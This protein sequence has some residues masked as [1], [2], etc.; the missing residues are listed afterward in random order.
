MTRETS[1]G[2]F[3]AA[4]PNDAPSRAQADDA[5]AAFNAAFSLEAGGVG[6]YRR[7]AA[8]RR[9]ASFWQTAELI[10]L[11]ADSYQTSADPDHRRHIRALARGVQLR[12]GRHWT[13]V[14][15][16]NDDVMWMVLAALRAYDT[17]SDVHC[18][19]AATANFDRAW[20]RAWSP[21]LGGG[22]WW[23]TARREKNACVNGPAAIAACRLAVALDDP[24]YLERARH[25]YAWVRDHLYEEESGRVN[26]HVR[27]AA[28]GIV[29]DR[30]LF[31][32]NQGTFIGAADLL[33]RLTGEQVYR[34]DA[35]RALTFTRTELAP[36]GILRSE[37]AAGD[38]GGFKGIF[39]RY[40]VP[41][42]RRHHLGEFEGWLWL[43]AAAAWNRRDARGLIGEDW[44]SPPSAARR[45]ESP[46]AWDASSA[47]VLLQLLNAP[48]PAIRH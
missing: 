18:L 39:A 10:E 34:D 2:G 17:W 29:L 40:A 16:Y 31:T 3:T 45:C 21:D 14:R 12:Y 47:V 24:R 35:H 19:A 46:Y 44:S 43:N 13:L 23:T 8:T 6:F 25:L 38:G 5:L 37:G 1:P 33:H 41:F 36:G 30:R 26:D 32:Y 27:A 11:V 22:L 42:V 4:R 20:R 7:H 28:S 48:A 15:R 9:L